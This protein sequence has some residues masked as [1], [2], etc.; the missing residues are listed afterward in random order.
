MEKGYEL[1]VESVDSGAGSPV[2]WNQPEFESRL[3]LKMT[4]P[5]FVLNY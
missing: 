4:Y 2:W 1:R 5:K 3:L